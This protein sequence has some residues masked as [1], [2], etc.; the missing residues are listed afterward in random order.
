MAVNNRKDVCC[1]IL[2]VSVM[3]SMVRKNNLVF[4]QCTNTNVSVKEVIVHRKTKQCL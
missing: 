2:S 4:V 1:P 3:N